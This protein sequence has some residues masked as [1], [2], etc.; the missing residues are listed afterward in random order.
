MSMYNY[1]SLVLKQQIITV[2]YKATQIIINVPI[3]MYLFKKQDYDD[4]KYTIKFLYVSTQYNVPE[5]LLNNSFIPGLNTMIHNNSIQ[6]FIESFK[7]STAHTFNQIKYK[8]QFLEFQSFTDCLYSELF[9]GITRISIKDESIELIESSSLDLLYKKIL[10]PFLFTLVYVPHFMQNCSNIVILDTSGNVVYKPLNEIA[11]GKLDIFEKITRAY[12]NC[13]YKSYRP[14]FNELKRR[15]KGYMCTNLLEQI[16]I[17]YETA[18]EQFKYNT[19]ALDFMT[20]V[21]EAFYNAIE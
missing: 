5:Y 6:G 16:P 7:I 12:S 2:W 10:L 21:L 13:I 9:P 3:N 15:G 8:P 14:L 18:I 20:K 19:H 17:Y 1:V 4:I 11:T